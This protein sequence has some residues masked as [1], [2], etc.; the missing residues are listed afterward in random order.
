M[1]R[2]HVFHALN[3]MLHLISVLFLIFVKNNQTHFAFVA[4]VFVGSLF[5]LVEHVEV[6]SQSFSVNRVRLNPKVLGSRG[7]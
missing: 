2:K 1:K 4:D 3:N 7:V 6:K 5:L